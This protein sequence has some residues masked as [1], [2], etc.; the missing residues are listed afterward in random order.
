MVVI[1]K[2]VLFIVSEVLVVLVVLVVGKLWDVIV[3]GVNF[4]F[5]FL[6]VL[7]GVVSAFPLLFLVEPLELFCCLLFLAGCS[8]MAGE[9]L[10]IV[11]RSSSIR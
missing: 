4:F 9:K 6:G 8:T 1:V 3:E 10:G 11:S 7:S 5:F 2:I